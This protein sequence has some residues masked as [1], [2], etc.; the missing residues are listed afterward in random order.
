MVKTLGCIVVYTNQ[1]FPRISNYGGNPSEPVGE[2]LMSHSST[3]RFYVRV[4][5]NDK[6][7]IRLKDNV[8]LPE[9]DMEFSLGWGGFYESSKERTAVGPVIADY[10]HNFDEYKNLMG[11]DD[12]PE[13]GVA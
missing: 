10:L 5:Q 13:E 1:V 8:G 11:R 3:H 7:K 9:F 12:V 4:G 2:H 6:R